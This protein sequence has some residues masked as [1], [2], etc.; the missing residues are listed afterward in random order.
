MIELNGIYKTKIIKGLKPD[1]SNYKVVYMQDN[2]LVCEKL[3]GYMAGSR[4][5]FLKE[6]MIDPENPNDIY[7]S[8]ELVKK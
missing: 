7:A 6:F 2:L 5:C 1:E 3:D 4:C 8:F